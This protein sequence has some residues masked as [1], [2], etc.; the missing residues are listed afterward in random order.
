MAEIGIVPHWFR[1]QAHTLARE[2]IAVFESRGD[3]VRVPG[4]DAKASG[5]DKWAVPDE[6]FG[7]GLALACS[8]GGDGTMLHT[9]ELVARFDVPVFGVNVGHLGYLAAAQ[10]EEL[11]DLVPRLLAGQYEIDERMTLAVEIIAAGTR[12]QPESRASILGAATG[13]DGEAGEARSM[14]RLAR[15]HLALNEAVLEKRASGHTV[16]L[17]VHFNDEFFTNYAADGL[18]VATPTGSTAYALSARGPI[19]SPR[20]SAVV[21]VP[22]SP[23]TLFDRALVLG[24]HERVRV[25]VLDGR[26]AV[27]FVDGRE[28]ATLDPGSA[29]SCTAGPHPA[30][31]VRF[32]DRDFHQILKA[33]FGLPGP[34]A[35]PRW[36][37]APDDG[38]ALAQSTSGVDGPPDDRERSC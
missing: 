9:V 24:P 30:L 4:T 18:I 12:A 10:P 32:A 17:G 16:R 20:L 5:L 31:L 3:I 26:P 33:K 28:M 21:V 2:L 15:T 7:A 13:T 35:D 19:V 8:L 38:G 25:E 22:V 37:V 14:E 23:H 34:E 29:I 36:S 6:E 1:S 11:P 27:L